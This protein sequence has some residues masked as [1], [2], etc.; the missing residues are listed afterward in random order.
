MAWLSTITFDQLAISFLTLATIR[1]A[2]VQLLPDDI[3]GP[4]GWLVDTGAE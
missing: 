2:M 4:G 1:G 3:A